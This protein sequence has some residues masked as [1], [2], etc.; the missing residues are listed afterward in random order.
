MWQQVKYWRSWVSHDHSSKVVALTPKHIANDFE[1]FRMSAWVAFVAC[2]V[3]AVRVFHIRG[4]LPEDFRIS[5][6]VL[7]FQADTV[8]APLE[9]ERWALVWQGDS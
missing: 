5:T 8:P 9:L 4:K 2:A 6:R 7:L 1:V 3:E